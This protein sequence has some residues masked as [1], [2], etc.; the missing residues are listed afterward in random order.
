[1]HVYIQ[2]CTYNGYMHAHL[3]FDSAVQIFSPARKLER[4]YPA[5]YVFA[6]NWLLQFKRF[7]PTGR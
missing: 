4:L 6:I 5:D 7:S 1:M 3:Y 2:V